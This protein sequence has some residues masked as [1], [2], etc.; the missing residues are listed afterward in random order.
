MTDLLVRP[1]P[2]RGP[3]PPGPRP[4]A[5]SLVVAAA[6]SAVAAVGF[7]LLA[8]VVPVVL[9]WALEPQEGPSLAP[10]LRA[11][12]DLWLSSQGAGLRVTQAS[13]AQSTVGLVPLGLSVLTA[14]LLVRAGRRMGERF[15]AGRPRQ[16]PARVAAVA[17]PYAAVAAAVAEASG[18][19]SVSA[20]PWRAAV[21]ALVLASGCVLSG[22]CPWR[23]WRDGPLLLAGV[24]RPAAVSVLVLVA[25]GALLAGASLAVH[26]GAASSIAR[27]TGSGAVGA[28]GLLV[29]SVCLLPNAV[30]WGV[31]YLLGSGF[32]VG[33]G[34]AVGPF[35]THLGITPGV[36]LVAALP[37][38]RPPGWAPAVL[39]VAVLAGVLG[40]RV[41]LRWVEAEAGPVRLRRSAAVCSG[42]TAVAG[43]LVT[44]MAALS[45]G[46]L[47]RGRLSTVGPSPW[48]AGL[49]AAALVGLGALAY[50]VVVA[51]R[52][53]LAARA[54]ERAAAELAAIDLAARTG[55]AAGGEVAD[56]DEGAEPPGVTGSAEGAGN[57]PIAAGG[58]PGSNAG[59]T[60]AEAEAAGAPVADGE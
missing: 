33:A 10:A 38:G 3:A 49:A 1:A 57:D 4:S 54:D 14:A 8:V 59:G 48:R 25:G 50:A 11:A 43:V 36:P 53:R 5:S 28:T 47:V 37:T 30:V 17:L 40:A 41:G 45:G 19:T 60:E 9:L 21:G 52:R 7:G 27:E 13:G 29:I 55:V 12:A 2:G 42:A 15:P 39:L 31:S 58:A 35:S 23:P 24:F 34:T 6:G 22:A 26:G 16:V 46:P 51:L 44:A 56:G 20:A 18:T 32:S